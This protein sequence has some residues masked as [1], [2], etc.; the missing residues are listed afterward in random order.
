[1]LPESSRRKTIEGAAFQESRVTSKNRNVSTCAQVSTWAS[2]ASEINPPA[3]NFLTF[4]SLWR[5]DALTACRSHALQVG[6]WSSAPEG[7]CQPL[8]W[9][10]L[11]RLVLQAA[12]MPHFNSHPVISVSDVS[13]RLSLL[14]L[15]VTHVSY[16][17]TTRVWIAVFCGLYQ[18]YFE[19]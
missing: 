19:S 12:N 3:L 9:G 15:R 2:D 5:S 16:L 17:S 13:T 7:A 10:T 14:L 6:W 4:S 8:I 1:M 18:I 11:A